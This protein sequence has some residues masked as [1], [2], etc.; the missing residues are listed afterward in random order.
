MWNIP[1]LFISCC[2]N[3][4]HPWLPQSIRIKPNVSELIL[5]FKSKN[6]ALETILFIVK[7]RKKLSVFLLSAAFIF[8]NEQI[9]FFQVEENSSPLPPAWS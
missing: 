6:P 1:L 9:G 8:F 4:K 5:A 2:Q 7:E 3:K